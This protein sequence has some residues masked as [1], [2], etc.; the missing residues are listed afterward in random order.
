MTHITRMGQPAGASVRLEI[1]ELDIPLGQRPKWLR[2]M[3][4]MV[5]R[6]RSFVY[7]D[8]L[9]N[10]TNCE[11]NNHLCLFS[12]R[13]DL[14]HHSANERASLFSLSLAWIDFDGALNFSCPTTSAPFP[15]RELAGV[16][17]TD[18]F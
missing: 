8:P 16:Y 11:R 9:S 12:A 17:R 18:P 7:L 1:G 2:T 10:G 6:V 3:R 5:F 15:Y 4:R 13:L 14:E